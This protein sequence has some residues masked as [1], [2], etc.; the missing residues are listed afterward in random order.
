MEQFE[1]AHVLA[2]HGGER[3]ARLDESGDGTRA[4]RRVDRFVAPAFVA[5]RAQTRVRAQRRADKNVGR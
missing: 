2:R 3:V 4:P 5:R 1:R